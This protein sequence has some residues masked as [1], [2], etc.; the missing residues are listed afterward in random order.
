MK[1]I[2]VFASGSGTNAINLINHFKNSDRAWVTVIFCNNPEAGIIKKAGLESVPVV[3]F[4][5]QELYESKHIDNTLEQLNIDV[6]VLAGFLWLF[7]ERLIKQFP[8]RVLNI[9]PALLPKYGGKGMYG[10]RV[11]KAV[12]EN[13]DTIHGVT[14]HLVN[15]EYDKGRILLQQSFT[16][17]DNDDLN[18][19]AEK[20]HAIEYQIYPQAI[21]MLLAEIN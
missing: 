21:D 14:V 5:R 8:D 3:L 11:H 12:L 19:V 9:H 7:P 17:A 15:E 10:D 16:I 2:A 1:N 18:S 4:D 6:I 13:G 20:I